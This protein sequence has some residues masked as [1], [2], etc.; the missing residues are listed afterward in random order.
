MQPDGEAGFGLD[1]F[2]DGV[3]IAHFAWRDLRD[4]TEHE[5]TTTE[6]LRALTLLDWISQHPSMK[7]IRFETR[8]AGRATWPPW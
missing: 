8:R 2:R 7:L 1:H 5:R 3:S 6:E 4:G